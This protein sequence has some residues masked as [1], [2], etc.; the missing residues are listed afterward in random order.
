MEVKEE[1]SDFSEEYMIKDNIEF[2]LIGFPYSVKNE[3]SE[4]LFE[5]D[6]PNTHTNNYFVDGNT[7]DKVCM[8]VGVE[9]IKLEE[10]NKTEKINV[11]NDIVIKDEIKEEFNEYGQIHIENHFVFEDFKDEPGKGY[12]S[13]NSRKNI[14]GRP[15]KY[16]NEEERKAAS[17][18]RARRRRANQSDEDR[19]KEATYKRQYRAKIKKNESEDRARRQQNA[20]SRRKQRAKASTEQVLARRMRDAAAQRLRRANESKEKAGERRK[21]DAEARRL[22]RRLIINCEG[23]TVK[24]TRMLTGEEL[25]DVS[26][27]E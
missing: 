18:E 11:K 21:C 27:I 25:C 17:R 8:E 20:E 15:K 3:I 7:F 4:D 12:Y 14:G 23:E 19:A 1:P 10:Q 26:T 22:R 5:A 9:D 6:L 2:S 24:H 13:G 16:Q